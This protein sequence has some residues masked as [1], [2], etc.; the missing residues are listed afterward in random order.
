[1]SL[2]QK[3]S[4]THGRRR[5]IMAPIRL[6]KHLNPVSSNR[7]KSKPCSDEVPIAVVRVQVISGC[8][9]L[10]KDKKGTSSDPFVVMTLVPNRQTTPVV[11]K[12]LDPVF[13]SNE[14]TFDFPIY[15]SVIDRLGALEAVV[16]D[17]DILRKEYLGETA[18][19]VQHWFPDG[20]AV[21]WDPELPPIT[22]AL[23][24][25][26]SRTQATGSIQFRIGFLSSTS[27]NTL[28]SESLSSQN[29]QEVYT[30]LLKHASERNLHSVPAFEGIGTVTGEEDEEDD[31]LSVSSDSSDDEDDSDMTPG[32][33]IAISPALSPSGISTPIAGLTLSP[34]GKLLPGRKPGYFDPQGQGPGSVA[35]TPGGRSF[36]SRA[37]RRKREKKS[38]AKKNWS[39]STQS[40]I[41]GVAMVEIKSA[42]D[43]PRLKNFLKTG[44]D[45]DPFVV[46]SFGKKVFRTRVIRHSLNPVWD[47]KLLFHVKKFESSFVIQFNILD[48]DKISGNDFVGVATLP[49]S[50]LLA[51]SPEPD[52][53]TGLHEG[54]GKHAMREFKLQLSTPQDPS[55]ETKH[56]PSITVRAKYEPY[57]ALRQKFWREYLKS[58]DDDNSGKI[59]FTELQAMLD[60]LGSTLTDETLESYFTSYLLDPEKDE[61]TIEQVIKSLEQEVKKT[62]TEKK[63]VGL[64]ESP[65][66]SDET[67]NTA[68]VPSLDLIDKKGQPN[69]AISL[70]VTGPEAGQPSAEIPKVNLTSAAQNGDQVTSE[71]NQ[72]PLTDEAGIPYDDDRENEEEEE[73]GP[74]SDLE[75][76][77]NI[78]ECPLCHRQRLSKRA[79]VDIVTHLAVCASADWARVNR[80]LV[81]NYVT[82]SQAQRKWMTKV[83]TKVSSGAY[84]IGAN[85]ANILVQ[86]RQTGQLLEEKMAVYVRLGIRVL[87]KGAKSR[88]EGGRARRLLKNMSF[89]QGIKYDSPESV[90]DIAPFI[91]FHRL[92]MDEILDPLDS[93]KTFNEPE[94]RPVSDP[95]DPNTLVSCADCRLMAFDTVSDAKKIW[96]KG[97][98][99]TI[100]RLLGDRYGKEAHRYDGGA[101]AV[102]RLAP[103]DYHRF[104]VPVDGV[105]GEIEKIEGAYYT[106]NPQAIRTQLDV[107]GENVRTIVP[108]DSPTFGRMFAI[109]VGAM[110]VG[111]IVHTVESGDTVVR[112]QEFGYFAFGGSTI[113]LVLEDGA[114]QWDE[115]LRIN[116]QASLETLVQMGTRIGR[117]KSPS[118]GIT[119]S[120]TPAIPTSPRLN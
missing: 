109:C 75:R 46:T 7:S 62:K 52:A 5:N 54:D 97:R 38:S 20:K 13:P 6:V 30:L 26:R 80:I 100:E 25:S 32:S 70:S 72:I 27:P 55:W 59:S 119:R 81:G 115:D 102:F 51:D 23:A 28:S 31:G 36:V 96:I 104:H 22:S 48:W 40:D 110:M 53:N 108:I 107:Y 69:H 44:F 37:S 83:F 24:S 10:G 86:D 66:F 2:D 34:D 4:R 8:D 116:C 14:S 89:K 21:A 57:D 111:T 93:F 19:Q 99:F 41:L 85:S 42:E 90:A 39:Y 92:N 15:G 88:M 1:M 82:S 29:F 50:E 91:A 101:V 49:L 95:T 114:V 67:P 73:L 33:A 43:L 18:L 120:S 11:K 64:E 47:E 105:V 63:H 56:K 45:M 61:L 112:G 117:K 94:V 106:V 60:S 77:I 65:S 79:E 58:Y 87:Y 118:I 78:K 68:D 35:A 3:V 17:K 16:W 84:Q 113:V 71:T 98:E 9:L 103:Q 76:V 74:D 12:T